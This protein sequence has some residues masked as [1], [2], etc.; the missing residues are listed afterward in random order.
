MRCPDSIGKYGKDPSMAPAV[1]LGRK[2]TDYSPPSGRVNF[3]DTL[4]TACGA[5]RQRETEPHGVTMRVG[6]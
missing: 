6:P 5:P 1:L 3:A 2:R 4:T